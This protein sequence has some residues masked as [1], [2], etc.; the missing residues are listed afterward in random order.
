LK[1]TPDKITALILV[2]GCL[3]LIFTG[4]NSEVKSILTMAAGWLFGTAYME[5]PKKGGK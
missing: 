1:W 4:R 3:G 2:V 5:R